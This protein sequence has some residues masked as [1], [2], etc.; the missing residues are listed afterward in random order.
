MKSKGLERLLRLL[1]ILLGIGLGLA[2]FQLGLE[3]YKLAY[4][5][6]GI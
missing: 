2:A 5:N 1:L 3:L 6:R 4:P